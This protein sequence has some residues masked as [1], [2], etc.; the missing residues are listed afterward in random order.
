[1]LESAQSGYIFGKSVYEIHGYSLFLQLHESCGGCGRHKGAGRNYDGSGDVKA[2]QLLVRNIV[3]IKAGGADLCHNLLDRR[4]SAAHTVDVEHH[5]GSGSVAGPKVIYREIQQEV[6]IALPCGK[7]GL[8]A[9]DIFEQGGSIF[10]HTAFRRHIDG[11][12]EHPSGE[13]CSL[14][15]V[16]C[17]VEIDMVHSGRESLVE[18]GLALA[19]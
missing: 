13:L 11:G 1:M 14:G 6:C 8:A 9:L 7:E 16:G 12:V 10:P 2:A 5:I 3:G 15:G 4:H 17:S 18:F 19:Q